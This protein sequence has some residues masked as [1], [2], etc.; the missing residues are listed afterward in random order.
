MTPITVEF[1]GLPRARAGRP[2]LAVEAATAA[3]ALAAAAAVCPGLAGLVAADGRLSPH[4]LVSLDG[5]RFLTDL[6]EP[7]PAGTRL[8]VLSAD[9][10]G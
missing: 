2:E 7:L 8:V 1:Y 10:G 3:D 4:Y 9:A 6:A 5:T